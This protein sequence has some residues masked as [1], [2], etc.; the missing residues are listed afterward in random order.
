MKTSQKITKK[1]TKPSLHRLQR[2]V[3]GPTRTD[4]TTPTRWSRRPCSCRR[5]RSSW[6]AATTTRR[7]RPATRVLQDGDR[8]FTPTGVKTGEDVRVTTAGEF[9]IF[10]LVCVP[11][12]VGDETEKESD[13]KMTAAGR[14]K[15][16]PL[17]KV[18]VTKVTQ[19]GDET[20]VVTKAG[21]FTIINCVKKEEDSD[22]KIKRM[23]ESLKIILDDSEDEFPEPEIVKVSSEDQSI[24]EACEESKKNM[25]TIRRDWKN[26]FVTYITHSTTVVEPDDTDEVVFVEE[27]R[28]R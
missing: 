21:I 22:E 11:G 19:V 14:F 27:I 26:G 10:N 18:Q 4:L 16:S 28:K 8:S 7:S 23:E 6:R 9:K 5:Q 20:K 2:P 15:I 24:M 3:R 17:E 25:V 13:V 1:T 12:V